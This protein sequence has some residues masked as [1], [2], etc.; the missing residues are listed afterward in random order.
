MSFSET[1]SETELDKQYD[2]V[3][4]L[5]GDLMHKKHIETLKFLR[6]V[7]NENKELRDR[8]RV[9]ENERPEELQ[10]DTNEQSI[11]LNEEEPNKTSIHQKEMTNQETQTYESVEHYDELQRQW[12]LKKSE[13]E[14]E[15]ER[16][17]IENEELKNQNDELIES[18]ESIKENLNFLNENLNKQTHKI[19]ELENEMEK[20]LQINQ[21]IP[22]LKQIIKELEDKI[23]EFENDL[24]EKSL[25]I[26]ELG[27]KIEKSNENEIQIQAHFNAEFEKHRLTLND[28]LNCAIKISNLESKLESEQHKNND[29]TL[30]IDNLNEYINRL[31]DEINCLKEKITYQESNMN[32]KEFIM[33]KRELNALKQATI[34]SSNVNMLTNTTSPASSPLPPLKESLLKK[35]FG[36]Q[37]KN[38]Y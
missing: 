13:Y 6:E 1:D 38:S 8:I 28:H 16:V 27:E 7:L 35:K 26:K 37:S 25:I 3:E 2:D 30:D 17:D 36:Q 19:L 20:L 10:D 23:Q 11:F 22:F 15:L 4:V 24:S 29:L 31:N 33:L 18:N 5:V 9:L 12:N 34:G 14:K 32:F 21:E